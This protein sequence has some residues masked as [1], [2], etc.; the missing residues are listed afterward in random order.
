MLIQRTEDGVPYEHTRTLGEHEGFL[1]KILALRI[2]SSECMRSGL[3]RVLT[4]LYQ[5][6][7]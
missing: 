6:K 7:V 5:T 3:R 4:S 1:R 2:V